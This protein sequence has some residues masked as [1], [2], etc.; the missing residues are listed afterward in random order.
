IIPQSVSQEP[1]GFA[2]AVLAGRVI[3]GFPV[4]LAYRHFGG[5]T[6]TG[7]GFFFVDPLGEVSGPL[8]QSI[9]TQTE[10]IFLGVG[11]ERQFGDGW[12]VDISLEAGAAFV[13]ANGI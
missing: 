5:R 13:R 3:D 11:L 9:R 6:A 2:A 4:R 12:F 8:P 10:S 7:N 1:W